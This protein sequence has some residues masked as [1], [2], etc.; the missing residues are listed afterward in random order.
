MKQLNK[1]VIEYKLTEIGDLIN[2]TKDDTPEQISEKFSTLSNYWVIGWVDPET[3]KDNVSGIFKTS[4]LPMMFFMI[5][6]KL[7]L[8]DEDITLY[9]FSDAAGK[10][11]YDKEIA[12]LT[13][14]EKLKSIL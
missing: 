1:D 5:W 10:P 3:K 12:N 7:K 13:T 2:L 6:W 14:V 11:I 4:S 9:A 8:K